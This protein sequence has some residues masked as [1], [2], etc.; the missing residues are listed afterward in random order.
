M[1]W[2]GCYAVTWHVLCEFCL[3]GSCPDIRGSLLCRSS[4]TQDVTDSRPLCMR[5]HILR[6]IGRDVFRS[7]SCFASLLLPSLLHKYLLLN[8]STH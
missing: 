4:L 2:S 6:S 8:P 5:C 7:S 3:G 1:D